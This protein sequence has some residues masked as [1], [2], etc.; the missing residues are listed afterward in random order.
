MMLH[1]YIATHTCI[2]SVRTV[3]IVNV[4]NFQLCCVYVFVVVWLS[5]FTVVSVCIVSAH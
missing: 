1:D 2:R 5:D 4:Y 3:S